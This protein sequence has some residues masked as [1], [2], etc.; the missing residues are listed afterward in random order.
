MVRIFHGKQ[1]NVNSQ[2]EFSI[3]SLEEDFYSTVLNYK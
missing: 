3:Q 1:Y 2:P